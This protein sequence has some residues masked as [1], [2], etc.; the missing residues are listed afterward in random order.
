MKTLFKPMLVLFAFVWLVLPSSLPGAEAPAA[1][2]PNV[3]FVVF[4]DL[5]N[6]LG[7][8]GDPVAKTPNLDRLAARGTAFERAY[9]QQPI[10]GPSR[11]SFMSGRRPDSLGI[12]SMTKFLYE[13]HPDAVTIPQWFMQH[14]YTAMSIGKVLGGYGKKGDYEKLSVPDRRTGSPTKDEFAMPGGAPLPPNL[15]K[16]RL[17]E[18][19]DV[20]DEACFDTLTAN[21]AI[22][23]LRSL[24]KKPEPFFLAVGFFKPHTP[25]KIPKR[26]WDL[27]RREDIPPIDPSQRPKDAPEIAFHVNHEFLGEPNERRTLDEEAERELRHGYYA[28]ISFAD[29]QLG[30]VLDALE[31]LKIAD[32][33]IVVVLS[34]NG[35][36]LGEHD[37]WGKMTLFDWDA[38]VPLIISAPGTGQSGVKSSALSELID[39]FPTL[40]ELCRL[41]NPPN[42]EGRSLVPVLKDAN[43]TVKTAALTQHPRP[44]LYWGGGPQALP[45][46]MGYGLKSDRWSYHE[47]RNF[48]TGEV[49]ARELY[50]EKADPL[51]TVNLADS[52]E[53]LAQIP[54]LAAQLDAMTKPGS[55]GR[56]ASKTGD[57]NL[58]ITTDRA[59]PFYH[60]GE[61][62]RFTI[63][64]TLDG[65]AVKDAKVKWKISK[66]GFGPP[67]Q[68]GTENP[69][70]GSFTVS[71]KLDEPGFLRCQAEV[72]IP[73]ISVP[74]AIAAAAIDPTEI[75]PSLPPPDD[76][77]AFWAGQKAK[78]A[79]IP[80]NLKL[81]PVKSPVAGV[82]VFDVQADAIGKPMSGYLARPVGAKP[83]SLPAIVLCHG[84]GVRSSGLDRAA[85]WAGNGFLAL[86]FNAHG[87]PNG[88]PAEFYENLQKTELKDYYLKNPQ[89]RETIFFLVLFHRLMR[90]MDVL[91]S[92]PE[93][94]GKHLVAEGGSQGGGQAIAAAALDPRVTFFAAQKP[95]MCDHTGMVVGRTS[96]WP[97]LVPVAGGKPDEP[98]L[99]AA[100]YFDAVNFARFAQAPAFFTVGFIDVVCP[101]TSVYAAYNAV[102]GE[103]EMADYIHDGHEFPPAGSAATQAAILKYM[104]SAKAAGR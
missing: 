78:L 43:A 44:A 33:T 29:A 88:Q 1:G 19:R 103:K 8:Y 65:V 68:E 17:C 95:A 101:P 25:F 26:Y 21:L 59:E 60:Q 66:D 83:Q 96:G 37:T 89:S 73:G 57:Y 64:L 90:A 30:R 35:F 27:Y 79:A 6:R 13:L 45:K 70:D 4:D 71:G 16:D 15:A 81:T 80:L 55:V 18:N 77:E 62:V 51:E 9:C 75:K 47:W 61:T 98:S 56:Q 69:G 82:E 41:P 22:Q 20:P 67:L 87:L 93:W 34:D 94:D 31:E 42:L 23:E 74:I 72:S 102:L 32:N 86:D 3:L 63:G 52:P 54:A 40:T 46:V 2:R 100:R 48:Q 14:G 39:L 12:T 104:K 24:S 38:R 85:Q 91:T 76:F 53:G 28:A 99:Q 58:R 36:Q 84:A 7:C 50:D 97:R 11:A 49:V 92:R 5:N 10:C